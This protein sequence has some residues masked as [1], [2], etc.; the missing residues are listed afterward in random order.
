LRYF[1]HQ[2]AAGAG[3]NDEQIG[4]VMAWTGLPQ[5]LLITLVP[6]LMKRFDAHY[7][8]LV[9]TSLFAASCRPGRIPPQRILKHATSTHPP[10]HI[11]QPSQMNKNVS[12]RE[13]PPWP[14]L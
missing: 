7:I 1:R 9:G 4:K 5:L 6:R 13:G 10:C 8:T 11:R 2:S 14:R 12:R 3:Y